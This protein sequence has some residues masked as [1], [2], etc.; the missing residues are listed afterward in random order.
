MLRPEEKAT[1]QNFC[2]TWPNFA[3][4]R[5]VCQEGPDPPDYVCIHSDGKR[6]GVELGEWLHQEQM[7][8][9]IARERRGESFTEVIRS[10]EVEPP[11]NIGL[12]FLKTREGTRLRPEDAKTFRKELYE[13]IEKLDRLWPRNPE[14]SD[15]QG[16]RHTDFLRYPSV[17]AYVEEL[18][19]RSRER[20]PTIRGIQWICFPA[21]GGAYTPRDA[22][23]ALLNVIRKKTAMYTGLRQQARLDEL[24]LVVYYDRALIYNTPYFAPGFDLVD[25]TKLAAA[26]VAKNPGAFRKVFLFNTLPQ[27]REVIQLWP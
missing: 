13:C 7:A 6:I 14:W 11:E 17:A 5:V 3:G 26:E 16:H 22:V 21:H 19:L 18:H 15:P 4:R 23:D 2:A 9:G 8:G 24:Y 12:A 20:Y 25:I 1:F 10:E 27:D